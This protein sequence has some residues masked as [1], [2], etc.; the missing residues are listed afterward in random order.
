MLA[1]SGS[2]RQSGR[3][4]LLRKLLAF[5]AASLRR[6]KQSKVSVDAA[7]AN[8]DG[9]IDQTNTAGVRKNRLDPQRQRLAHRL[10]ALSTRFNAN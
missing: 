5:V 3:S 8:H 2:A 7:K 4:R 9:H 6:A 10:N 1:M